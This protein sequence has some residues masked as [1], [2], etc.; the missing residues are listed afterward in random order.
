MV[1]S[2]AIDSD[3]K[4]VSWVPADIAIDDENLLSGVQIGDGSCFDHIVGFGSYGDVDVS[5]P[6]ILLSIGIL[7]HSLVL[8]RSSSSFS[9]ISDQSP[10]AAHC[11]RAR[12][13]IGRDGVGTS[14][15]IEFTNTEVS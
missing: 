1:D 9:R 3:F 10:C 11:G 2:R 7:D 13:R 8:G 6:D 12:A 14:E 4:S 15:F 5:P